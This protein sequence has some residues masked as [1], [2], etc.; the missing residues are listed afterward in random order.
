MPVPNPGDIV[1][2]HSEVEAGHATL[3]LGG[4]L[5]IYA[6]GPGIAKIDQWSSVMET[7]KSA[8]NLRYTP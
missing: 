7:H 5:L 2:F 8:R 6:G 1:A 4:D 3:F